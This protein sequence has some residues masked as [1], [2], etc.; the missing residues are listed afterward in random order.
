MRWVLAIFVAAG[1]GGGAPQ[2]RVVY[3]ERAPNVERPARHV[4]DESGLTPVPSL[5]ALVEVDN[6]A[7]K[8]GEA[9]RAPAAK[10]AREVVEGARV[11]ALKAVG[12]Q[13][14]TQRF[15]RMD[16]SD[17][18]CEYR[19]GM[20]Y[21]AYACAREQFEIEL[22]PLE[23]VTTD[24]AIGPNY[25]IG[26]RPDPATQGDG[27]QRAVNMFWALSQ[28][29]QRGDGEGNLV[30]VYRM[31][32]QNDRTIAKSL[33]MFGTNFGNYKLLVHVLPTGSNQCM[34]V[35][36]WHR[37]PIEM[38]RA[39]A[40]AQQASAELDAKAAK[41][42][43]DAACEDMR[44]TI[45]VAAGKPEWVPTADDGGDAVYNVCDGDHA[46]I[47]IQLPKHVQYTAW[48]VIDVE[49]SGGRAVAQCTPDKPGRRIV[50]DNLWRAAMLYMGNRDTAEEVV[51]IRRAGK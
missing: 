23:Q 26:G 9:L 10:S 46:Q 15:C 49:Q 29:M 12:D 33:V 24:V 20:T 51:Y 37:R 40:L 34:S 14:D 44:Y 43:S 50:C 16:L 4:D 28:Q 32:P 1:C 5:P 7:I 2:T 45:E 41:R 42:A 18:V 39:Q 22:A 13:S 48:P 25:M 6:A 19:R 8:D 31:Q 11:D 35:M 27:G 38:A 47:V 30:T 17:A 36:R 21:E 3:A